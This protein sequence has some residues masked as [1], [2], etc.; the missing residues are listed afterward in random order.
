[1]LSPRFVPYA[2]KQIV[3]H[4]TRSVLTLAGVA[5]AMFL[6]CGVQAMRAGAELATRKAATDNTLVVYRKDRYCPFASRMP[7]SYAPRIRQIAGV[8]SVVPMKIVVTNCR[9]SL[10]VVTFRGVPVEEFERTFGGGLKLIAG[11]FE[12]WR[13]RTDAVILGDALAQRRGLRVGDSFEAV[14]IRAYVAGIVHSDEPHH[15]NVAYAHLAFIQAASGSVQGGVVT[16]FNVRVA[17]PDQLEAVAAAIDAEF[18]S[19]AEPTHTRS[20]KA[21][22]A[23]A[24]RDVLEIIG[25]T[26]WLGWG[27]LIAVLALVGNA[28][29]LA[30]MDRVREHAVLQTLGY[31]GHLIGRL[32]LAEGLL[33]S[34]AG[35]LLGTILAALFLRWTRFALSVE[36]VSIGV[37]TSPAVFVQGMAIAVALGVLASLTPA[38]QAARRP[39]AACFRAV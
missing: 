21:F 3:R 28:I 19:D 34:V 37:S 10:D 18:V 32:I 26:Q 17:D 27:C 38:I 9:T 12:E 35:G 20:E 24:A 22:V 30:V 6:Y 14:N 13:R 33:L 31:K 36:G 25:F 7:E 8:A 2:L 15:Q 16:Q 5:V 11:S 29:A 23:S 1:M 4:P 39:I